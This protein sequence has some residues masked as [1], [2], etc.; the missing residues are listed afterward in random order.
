MSHEYLHVMREFYIFLAEKLVWAASFPKSK[1]KESKDKGKGLFPLNYTEEYKYMVGQT[2]KCI[3]ALREPE[4][5]LEY[6]HVS[7]KHK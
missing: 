2:D 5:G 7:F 4:I 6:T 3:E 1:D